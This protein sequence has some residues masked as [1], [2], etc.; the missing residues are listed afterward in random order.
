MKTTTEFARD[1]SARSG[2]PSGRPNAPVTNTVPLRGARSY[3]GEQW[4]RER[5]RQASFVP[6]KISLDAMQRLMTA[7]GVPGRTWTTAFGLYND[8]DCQEVFDFLENF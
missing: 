7:W 6:E 4:C 3:F 2:A 8:Y 5:D 1:Y